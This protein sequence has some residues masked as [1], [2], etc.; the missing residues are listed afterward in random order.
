M[1][2]IRADYIKSDYMTPYEFWNAMWRIRI[3]PYGTVEA[4]ISKRMS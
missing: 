1:S 4:I 3:D 2:E